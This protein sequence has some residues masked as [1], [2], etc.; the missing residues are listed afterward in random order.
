MAMNDAANRLQKQIDVLTEKRDEALA[1]I[2]ELE[3]QQGAV[4]VRDPQRGAKELQAIATEIASRK[5]YVLALEVR[6]EQLK[7]EHG[8]IAKRCKEDL[9]VVERL[10]KA[11]REKIRAVV[12]LVAALVAALDDLQVTRREIQSLGGM[13]KATVPAGLHDALLTAQ[14]TWRLAGVWH[15]DGGSL[16]DRRT[17]AQIEADFEAERRRAEQGKKEMIRRG[18]LSR[19]VRVADPEAW[20]TANEKAHYRGLGAESSTKE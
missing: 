18:R 20:L 10:W 19:E 4:D 11:E 14:G 8:Q 2:A 9:K 13:A 15:D 17:P 6:L 12:D 5:N 1:R 16:R 7:A 3:A